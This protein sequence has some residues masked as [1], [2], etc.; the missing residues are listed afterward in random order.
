M[1]PITLGKACPAMNAPSGVMIRGI[2]GQ[3]GT[4]IAA[5][6]GTCIIRHLHQH[7]AVRRPL[8]RDLF[9]AWQCAC[10]MAPVRNRVPFVAQRQKMNN[11]K[12]AQK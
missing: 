8:Q 3:G 2:G 7:N 4:R 9:Y 12:A 1:M 11:R 10:P 6:S 5:L